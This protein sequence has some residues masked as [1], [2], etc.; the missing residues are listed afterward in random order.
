MKTRFF[1]LLAIVFFTATATIAGVKDV[2]TNTPA[3]KFLEKEI[4]YPSAAKDLELSGSVYMTITNKDGVRL[5]FGR[6]D[7]DQLTILYDVMR[8]LKRLE[9]QLVQL[10]DA[11]ASETFKFRFEL[12]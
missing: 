4:R 1:Y 5:E 7:F 2:E 12:K 3:A 6:I 10:I 9:P 11:D 8:Q